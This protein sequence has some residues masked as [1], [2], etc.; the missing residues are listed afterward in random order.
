MPDVLRFVCYLVAVIA[1][2]WAAFSTT[3]PRRVRNVT[4]FGLAFAFS[5]L[6]WD[7]AETMWRNGH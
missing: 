4:A 6:L 7:A 2:L 5:P 3:P 1:F